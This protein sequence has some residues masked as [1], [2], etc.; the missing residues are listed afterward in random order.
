[1][2]DI[3]VLIVLFFQYIGEVAIFQ[4]KQLKRKRT[5]ERGGEIIEG[6]EA[7]MAELKK[8]KVSES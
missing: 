6:D 4:N 1:M 2:K 3:W 8:N 5:H 7:W